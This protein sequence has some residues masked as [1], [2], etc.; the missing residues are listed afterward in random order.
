MISPVQETAL[1]PLN[2][3]VQLVVE[4]GAKLTRP[5]KSGKSVQ[6]E[7]DLMSLGS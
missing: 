2:P 3:N 6:L 4:P 7:M 1:C 5:A